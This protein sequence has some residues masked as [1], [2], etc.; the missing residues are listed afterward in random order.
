[1]SISNNTYPEILFPDDLY[2]IKKTE[3]VVEVYID[4][5]LLKKDTRNLLVSP[6]A[7]FDNKEMK[8]R[9]DEAM[10]VLPS[11]EKDILKRRFGIGYEEQTLKQVA[12][13]YNVTRD[14]YS[15]ASIK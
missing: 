13:E 9:L 2:S 8:E 5:L 14:P 1:M 6:E 12:D 15:P 11:K 7:I 4:K 3:G 10:N